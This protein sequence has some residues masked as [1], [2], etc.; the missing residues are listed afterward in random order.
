MTTEEKIML[1]RVYSNTIKDV[2]AKTYFL[3]LHNALKLEKKFG[4]DIKRAG[5]EINENLDLKLVTEPEDIY[6]EFL[7][8][9][10]VYHPVR[11]SVETLDSIE[12]IRLWMKDHP[13]YFNKFM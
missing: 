9:Y 10:D 12:S 6:N 3:I 4:E 1:L 13:E 2:L 7:R 5:K 11:N 8:L